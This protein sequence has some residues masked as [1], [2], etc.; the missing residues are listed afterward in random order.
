MPIEGVDPVRNIIKAG[1]TKSNIGPKRSTYYELIVESVI[2]ADGNPEDVVV[3]I[4]FHPPRLDANTAHQIWPKV[5]NQ[6]TNEFIKAHPNAKTDHNGT[7]IK[8]VVSDALERAGK[9]AN[10]GKDIIKS[11]FDNGWLRRV[12]DRPEGHNKD[13]KRVALGSV[14]PAVEER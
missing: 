9:P 1:V 13:M 7:N 3:P 6:V 2:C 8:E 11:M 5:K 14:D 12:D 4:P 10:Q